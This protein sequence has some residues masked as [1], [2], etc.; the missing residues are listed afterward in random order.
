[1]NV[2]RIAGRGRRPGLVVMIACMVLMQCL[3]APLAAQSPILSPYANQ[4]PM[5]GHDLGD[6]RDQPFDNFLGPSNVG[7][8]V[9]KWV[10]TTGGDV[11]ATPAVVNGVV[12]F[13][14]WSGHFY[15]VNATTGQLIRSRRVSD[16]TGIV[17]DLVR[18]DPAFFG[19]AILLGDQ[20][21]RAATLSDGVLEGPG[22]RM[23]SVDART[24]RLNWVTQVDGFPGA[25]I[26]GS[27]VVFR[28]TVYVGISSLEE[29]LAKS[30][31]Y[32]CCSFRGSVVA[33]DVHTGRILWKT[34]DM[35]MPPANPG[36][37][38]GGAVWGSTPV[39]N[40]VRG[41]LYVGTGNNYTTPLA[42]KNCVAKAQADGESDSVCDGVDDFAADHFDSVLALDLRT[43]AV[44]W[45]HRLEGY[46]AWTVACLSLPPGVTW[47][48]SP[49]GPDY[50]VGGAGP[51][52]FSATVRGQVRQIVG[53]GQKSGIYWALDAGNGDVLW[54]TLV[55][56][57]SALGGIEWGTATDGQ[58]VYVPLANA[59]QIPYALQPCCASAD[60]G[61]WAALDPAS[62]RILWQTAVP[63]TCAGMPGTT[64]S[65]M[66]LGPATV[67]NGVVYVGSMDPHRGDP[68]MFALD[69][70]TGSI[71][72]SFAA[73]SSV[74]AAPAVAGGSLYWGSGYSHLGPRIGTGNDK[75]YAFTLP[76]GR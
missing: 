57:G 22:A 64:G 32:P 51:N 46:D 23:M 63:G 13:P 45:A 30:F 16:W 27:P 75:L 26:T 36:G 67:A 10:F 8:L 47:C 11:S 3:P 59:N 7:E 61:S 53:V 65:C 21:G 54:Q 62:G 5:G 50:D 44:R 35:P 18:D 28:G 6:T 58:R 41:Q 17:G 25:V 12:Y 70:S 4:W 73:G 1:M 60:G 71:L 29:S 20:G 40:P 43:G 2:L 9:T 19:G 68:T 39:V 48:P 24:G 66:A 55:G 42:V 69:A 52:F 72:W 38:S 31:S 15:A 49:S 14:D 76:G 74:N 56:P 37:Y 34:H 33:L